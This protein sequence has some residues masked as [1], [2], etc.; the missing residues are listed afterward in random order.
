MKDENELTDAALAAS[1]VRHQSPMD[2]DDAMR[3]L[4]AA[5]QIEKGIQ[6]GEST[7]NEMSIWASEIRLTIKKYL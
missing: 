7:L 5:C 1:L 6:Y 3:I 2:F 4:H